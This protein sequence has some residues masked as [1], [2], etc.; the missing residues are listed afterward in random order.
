MALYYSSLTALPEGPKGATM[1]LTG[2][3]SFV[4]G[5]FVAAPSTELGRVSQC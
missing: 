1:H 3:G 5:S 4:E 2:E